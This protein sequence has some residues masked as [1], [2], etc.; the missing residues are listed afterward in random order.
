[1]TIYAGMLIEEDRCVVSLLNQHSQLQET[2]YLPAD[3]II[4]LK[5]LEPYR[6][7]IEGIAVARKKSDF[8]LIY[9]LMEAG[10]PVHLLHS[11]LVKRWSSQGKESAD[12]AQLLARRLRYELAGKGQWAFKSPLNVSG[13]FHRIKGLASTGK[14][15]TQ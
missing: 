14:L 11:S 3:L 10:Y 1:M 15:A 12:H 6:F 13:I 9:G 5:K 2:I 4:L 8:T 7:Q